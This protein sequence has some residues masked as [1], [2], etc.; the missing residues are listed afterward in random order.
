MKRFVLL[1]IAALALFATGLFAGDP[2]GKWTAEVEGRN[3]QKRTVTMNLKA[4]GDKLTGTVT[5]MGGEREIMDGKISGDEISFAVEVE[6]QGE[7]RKIE[8][9]GKMV[10]DELKMK[11]GSGER[12]REFTAK[13]TTS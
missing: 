9:T 7:K 4:A 12:T 1:S 5:Q 13:R 3:G 11:S 8:Y 10:G 6:F 2:S